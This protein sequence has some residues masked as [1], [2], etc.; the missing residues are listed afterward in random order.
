SDQHDPFRLERHY[1]SLIRA[2]Q[3]V[4]SGYASHSHTPR[5]MPLYVL[6]PDQ[7]TL[8]QV[9][10]PDQGGIALSCADSS[11]QFRL[12]LQSVRHPEQPP[13]PPE[14]APPPAY[15]LFDVFFAPRAPAL[16]GVGAVQPL[17]VVLLLVVDVPLAQPA[18]FSAPGAPA[19]PGA[20]DVPH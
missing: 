13:S 14:F 20:G 5:S 8:G 12:C 1:S 4:A 7:E 15:A 11:A 10:L 9:L 6:P 2:T 18:V 17:A 3:R 19:L 16:P